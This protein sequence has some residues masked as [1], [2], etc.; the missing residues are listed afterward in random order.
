MTWEDLGQTKPKMWAKNPLAP[1]SWRAKTLSVL[2][3]V[4]IS[5][6]QCVMTF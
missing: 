3:S 4:P 6:Y 1:Q 2:E 5:T